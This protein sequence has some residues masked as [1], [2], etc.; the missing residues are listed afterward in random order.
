MKVIIAGGR[1][2]NDYS[3]LQKTIKTSGFDITEVVSGGA[4]GVDSMGE[5]WASENGVP[6]KEF[7]AQWG[8]YG[9]AAGPVRNRQMAEYAE[10]LI[11]IWDGESKGSA[12]ML[13]EAKNKNLKILNV[14]ISAE[15]V[16]V[17][18]RKHG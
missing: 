7:P 16:R 6:T 8:L 5:R 15:K 12:N 3:F 14:I 2:I 9:P 18:E 1:K 10:A 17:V 11:L 13:K 4:F